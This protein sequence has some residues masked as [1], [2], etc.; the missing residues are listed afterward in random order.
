MLFIFFTLNSQEESTDTHGILSEPHLPGWGGPR[1]GT[2][3]KYCA[4]QAVIREWTVDK[5]QSCQRRGGGARINTPGAP[6]VAKQTK[7]T[8]LW[9]CAG[10]SGARGTFTLEKKNNKHFFGQFVLKWFTLIMSVRRKTALLLL[11]QKK[12]VENLEKK[13]LR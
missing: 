3:N 13:A 5:L 9:L 10:P 6:A 1:F 11:L 2:A 4:S 7:P 8:T 12:N